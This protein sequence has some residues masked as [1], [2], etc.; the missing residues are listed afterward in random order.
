VGFLMLD[1]CWLFHIFLSTVLNSH[2]D[3]RTYTMQFHSLVMNWRGKG[4]VVGNSPT[5]ANTITYC[6]YTNDRALAGC[7]DSRLASF[8]RSTE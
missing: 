2:R 4:S 8:L 7:F 3:Q 5:I 6:N 1:S